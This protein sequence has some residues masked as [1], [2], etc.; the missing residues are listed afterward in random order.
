MMKKTFI[1]LSTVAALT[2]TGMA[3]AQDSGSND[4]MMG[5]NP[6]GLNFGGLN[7]DSSQ[8]SA[9]APSFMVGMRTSDKLMPFG[10][11]AIADNGGNTDTVIGFG[12][13][14]RY[15]LDNISQNV[16]PFAGASAGI[17]SAEDTGFGIGGFFGAEAMVTDAFSVSGQ[18]G[19]EIADQGGTNS[20]TVFQLGTAN[21]MF[22]LYF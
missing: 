14:A 2:T 5:F 6:F 20:D 17:I 15:Y 10:Y 1:A 22:N 13:G 8:I 18:V 3:S 21:V 12:G 9:T 11:A 16:R 19:L 4:L 7:V